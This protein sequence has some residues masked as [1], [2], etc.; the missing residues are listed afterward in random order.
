M[1]LLINIDEVRYGGATEPIRSLLRRAGNIDWFN[2]R[3]DHGREV[4]ARKLLEAHFEAFRRWR[5][6]MASPRSVRLM[7][8]D[9]AALSGVIDDSWYR[10]DSPP[11]RTVLGSVLGQL[12]ALPAYRSTV[13]ELVGPPIWPIA[14]S[15]TGIVNP[16]I[17]DEAAIPPTIS[18]EHWDAAW[19]LLCYADSFL[20]DAITWALHKS[21]SGE[22]NPFETLI[23]MVCEQ[24]FPL[25]FSGDGTFHV[26][27][28]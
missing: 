16:L 25:G 12:E 1:T 2:G 26:F 13:A 8:K 6:S 28:A 3:P 4:A 15:G 24:V 20:H 22:E 11:W 5:P 10:W 21:G 9:W 23:S 19:H 18:P 14:G 17:A 7:Y 27:L